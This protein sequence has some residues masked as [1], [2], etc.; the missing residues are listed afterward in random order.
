M[1]KESSAECRET[2]NSPGWVGNGK[3]NP[4]NWEVKH[5]ALG[6]V[7]PSAVGH[8]KQNWHQGWGRMEAK[9]PN[10]CEKAGEV[11]NPRAAQQSLPPGSRLQRGFSSRVVLICGF[12]EKL[13][14]NR[15]AA[16]IQAKL[17]NFGWSSLF[18]VPITVTFWVFLFENMELRH[19]KKNELDYEDFRWLLWPNTTEFRTAQGQDISTTTTTA[20]FVLILN[21]MFHI[22][23]G[24]KR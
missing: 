3:P 6:K 15:V 9:L 12:E 21:Y 23:T 1:Y 7:S 14:E 10:P 2:I 11:W 13:L 24:L 19:K 17:A 22:D 8:Y 20:I 16:W 4:K 18:W 5:S